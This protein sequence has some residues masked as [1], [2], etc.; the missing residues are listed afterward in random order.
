MRV[1]DLDLRT[2]EHRRSGWEEA[3]RA[4][5]PQA[6]DGGLRHL[7]SRLPFDDWRLQLYALADAAARQTAGGRT[8]LAN[9]RWTLYISSS[10]V[11]RPIEQSWKNLSVTFRSTTI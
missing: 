4:A 2:V 7:R 5:Y 10:P 9:Q 3:S 6:P 11:L 1:G 8:K